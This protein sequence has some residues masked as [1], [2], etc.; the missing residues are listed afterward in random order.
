M[1]HHSNIHSNVE[2][3]FMHSLYILYKDQYWHKKV[4]ILFGCS[5]TFVKGVTLL[6]LGNG[7]PDIFGAYAAIM[8][9]KEGDAGLAIGAIFGENYNCK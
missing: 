5:L 4:V 7:A 3:S 9:A 1:L 8:Q 2:H 6:A